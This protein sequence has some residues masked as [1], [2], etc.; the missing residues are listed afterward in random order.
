MIIG[1]AGRLELCTLKFQPGLSRTSA[2]EIIRPTA[3]RAE[4]IPSLAPFSS[5]SLATSRTNRLINR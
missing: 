3:I 1:S 2:A 5:S 4:G